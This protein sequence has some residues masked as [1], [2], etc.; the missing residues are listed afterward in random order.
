LAAFVQPLT[1]FVKNRLTSLR[2]NN[3]DMRVYGSKRLI[4]C[5]FNRAAL[6]TCPPLVSQY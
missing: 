6:M 1:R 2:E 5:I 4:K 3:N